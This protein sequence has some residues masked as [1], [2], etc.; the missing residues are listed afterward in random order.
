MI[1]IM[2]DSASPSL[3]LILSAG[4]RET[5]MMRERP[6]SPW[7]N[8]TRPLAQ[9]ARRQAADAPLAADEAAR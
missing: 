1:K 4:S 5:K 6:E 7:L 8:L 3:D 9:D 2:E